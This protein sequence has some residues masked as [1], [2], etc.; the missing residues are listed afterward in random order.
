[1]N[2]SDL[3]VDQQ[4]DLLAQQLAA[5][6]IAKT[7]KAKRRFLSQNR[8][9]SNRMNRPHKLEAIQRGGDKIM[10]LIDRFKVKPSSDIVGP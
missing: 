10:A 4:T 1:M 7:N 5:P 8:T 9:A 3:S 2:Q 6:I